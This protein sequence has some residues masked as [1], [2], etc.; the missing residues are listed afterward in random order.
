MVLKTLEEHKLYTNFKKYDFWMKKV[1][2]LGHVIPKEGVSVDPAKVKAVVNW[3]RP[4]NIIEVQSFLGMA[5][6]YR[7]F[8]ECFS[9][10]A[11]PLTKLLQKDNK[12]VWIEECEAS[13][14][15]RKQRLVLAPI[16]IIPKGNEGF[17]VYSDAFRQGLGVC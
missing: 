17:V 9:K 10:L 15:E 16:L 12:F 13:L 5:S 11:L 3:P 6:Y 8:I 1:Y 14:Q 7:R 2:F 4:I